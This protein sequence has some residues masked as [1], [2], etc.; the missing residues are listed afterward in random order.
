[1]N[2]PYMHVRQYQGFHSWSHEFY[3]W[4]KTQACD[5]CVMQNRLEI[6]KVY[7][8]AQIKQIID[9]YNYE[10]TIKSTNS[11]VILENYAKLLNYNIIVTR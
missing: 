8:I 1:M 5:R 3:K 2:I 9:S 7:Y 11:Y 10:N 4:N 6:D